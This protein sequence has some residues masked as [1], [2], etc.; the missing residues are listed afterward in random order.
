MSDLPSWCN[1]S[2]YSV[3]KYCSVY[4]VP[5]PYFVYRQ[6]GD[7]A[8]GAKNVKTIL[9][10]IQKLRRMKE[11]HADLLEQYH[12]AR[13]FLSIIYHWFVIDW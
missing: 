11:I 6:H 3:L 8:N 12:Q 4:F 2:Q 1:R 7:N 5:H 13:E 10:T 9:Y